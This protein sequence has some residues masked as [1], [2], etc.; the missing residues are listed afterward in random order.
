MAYDY[1]SLVSVPG[2][3]LTTFRNECTAAVGLDLGMDASL[4]RCANVATP[5]DNR[6]LASARTLRCWA[7]AR[8][9]T[10]LVTAIDAVL[11]Q[12]TGIP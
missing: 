9:R 7:E 5:T 8:G 11:S 2:A 12:A 1:D 10:A 4:Q 3:T 6:L